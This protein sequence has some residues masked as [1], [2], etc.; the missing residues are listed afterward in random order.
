[1]NDFID[2]GY[3]IITNTLIPL[4]YFVCL[5]YFAWGIAKYIKSIG[6]GKEQGRQIMIWGVVGLFVVTSIWG[7]IEFIKLEVGLPFD[8]S[9][10][11]A[12][13]YR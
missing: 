1:M 5:F 2:K 6:D 13:V 11:D 8:N 10:L 4:G 12:K 7:I 9:E 3:S